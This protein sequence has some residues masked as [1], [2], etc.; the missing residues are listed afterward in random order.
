MSKPELD[1][2]YGLADLQGDLLEIMKFIHEFCVANN[3]VYSLTGGSL[4]GS[5]R[6]GGFIPWDDDFDIM[7]DREN[8]EK[9]IDL[10]SK[11][12]TGEF[13]LEPDQWVYRVRKEHKTKGY[14]ASID[15]FVLDKV[16]ESNLA[17]K[18]QVLLLRV[19]QGMLRTNEKEGNF[20]F[21]YKVCI[22][23]TSV[24]GKLFK[25]EWLFKQYDRISQKGNGGKRN[26]LSIFND[27]FKLI[28]LKYSGDFMATTL[29]QKFEDTEFLITTKYEEYLT[30]QFGD[31]MTPPPDKERVPQHI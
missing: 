14:V 16:P 29:L 25:K 8:Y 23:V 1:N 22:A 31:Y 5:I 13:I 11:K 19:L 2:S 21:I 17:N 6:H 3:I 10:M 28:S 18:I 12:N 27:R 9:F 4:L 7:F 15:L 20:S 26:E 24:L 30:T